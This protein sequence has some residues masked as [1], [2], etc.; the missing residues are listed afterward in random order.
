MAI[1][2]TS[3]EFNQNASKVLKMAEKEPVLLPN[4]AKSSMWCLVIWIISRK[5]LASQALKSYSPL[6]KMRM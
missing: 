5:S 2:I 4:G 6:P 3:R 1:T